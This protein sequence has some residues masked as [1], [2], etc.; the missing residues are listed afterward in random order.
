MVY[1]SRPGETFLL[2][3]STWRI[4]D[5]TFER[6]VVTPAPGQPGKMPFW[7]GDRPGRPLELGRALGAF[8][9]EI[10]ELTAAAGG[11]AAADGRLRARRVRRQQR[12]ACTSTSRR[13]PPAWCPTTAPIVVERFRDEI[14]DWRVC[15]LSPFGTPVHAPWAMAIERRLIDR[16]D[17]PVE[18]MWGDDGIVAAP[19]RVGRR[20][21]AGGSDH[22][23]RRDRRAGSRRRCRRRRCSRP[24]SAS[25]RRAPCCCR[26]AGPDRRTPLWQQRQRAADLL[27]VAAEVPDV[28]DPA[29]DRHASACRTCS[30][31]RRCAR[32]SASCA[33]EPCVWSASTPP[34]PRRSPRACCSTGSPR[35]C[36]RVTRRWPNAAPRRCRWTAICCATCS[37]PKSCASCSTRACWPTSSW[38]CSAWP[39][40]AGPAIADELHDVLRKV[41]DL[42]AAEVDL[43]C[44]GDDVAGWLA[45][46]LHQRRAIEVSV[47]G[48]RSVHR[49]RGRGPLPRR[50]RLQRCRS[51][52]RWRS[53]NRCPTRWSRWSPATPAPTARS[54]RDDVARRFGLADRASVGALAALEA[55]GPRRARRVPPRRRRPRV[56]RRRRAPPTAAPVVGRAA[57]RGRAGRARR[58]TPGSSR[59]G[60][61]FPANGAASTR[62]SRRSVSCRARRW[63]PASLE[64]EVLPP[65]LRGYRPTDLDELCT[66]GDLVWVGAGAIGANDGRI[67]LYFADQLPLLAPAIE[68]PEPP[69]GRA[70]RRDPRPPRRA[71]R[72][73]LGPAARRGHRAPPTPSCWPRCGIWCGPARSP[74]TRWRRCVVLT[75]R[76]TKAAVRWRRAARPAPARSAHPHRPAAGRRSL[77]PGGAVAA[78]RRPS[79]PRPP[80]PLALQLLERYGVV[81]REAVLAEGVRRRLR[82]RVRR[83]EGARGARP[84][85][86]RLLRQP[87]SAPPS[88]ACPAPSTGCAA[89]RGARPRAAPRADARP[90]WC[91]PPPILPSRT[92]RRSPGPTQPGRPAAP[93]ARSSCCRGGCAAGV[94]RPPLAPPRHLSGGHRRRRWAEALAR[95]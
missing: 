54:S 87:V 18:T 49:R 84:G 53:P 66:S 17:M 76:G 42:T 8:Q 25:A 73:L 60:T 21:A 16:Y 47:G 95:W 81:T 46:L 7:H 83:A 48:E 3:A 40:A 34:R 63:S 45:E 28:P 19:A 78:S 75:A 64:T 58:A 57:P 90:R 32:C 72:Q 55:D 31:C 14:G 85:S 37:A 23:P 89:A 67:R 29:G 20:A 77:V 41:G 61:A 70:A 43:R 11:A 30:T 74:T 27:A 24:G 44:E 15:I 71:R 94:V 65:R 50:V 12:A 13:R 38:S 22:R 5:I 69:V 10:R 52:C 26:A 36:T 33:A 93:P 6:V 4:E 88:S 2:G 59:R 92:A 79:P 68:P 9:R 39:T 1:E 35:T 51:A 91:W 62:W 80:T 82:R 56:V 86:A